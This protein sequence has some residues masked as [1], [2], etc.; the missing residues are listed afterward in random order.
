LVDLFEPLGISQRDKFAAHHARVQL[1][2]AAAE[3]DVACFDCAFPTLRD[4]VGFATEAEAARGYGFSSKSCIHPGQIAAANQIYSPTAGEIA[5]ANRTVRAANEA[6][7]GGLG[8]FTLD[9]RTIDRP[10][11]RRADE[12]L[13]FAARHSSEGSGA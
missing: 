5:T 10:T 8:A 9:G 1:R 6:A 13:W 4:T 12:I 11:I 2:L 7:A 3:A